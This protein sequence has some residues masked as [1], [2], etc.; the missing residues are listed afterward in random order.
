MIINIGIIGLGW[1]A[2]LIAESIKESNDNVCVTAVCDID[3]RKLEEFND[4][5]SIEKIYKNPEWLLADN[6]IDMVI[7]ATPPFLHSRFAKKALLS[8]KHIF[9]EKPG[10]L[11]SDSM[12]EL[13]L[14]SEKKGLKATIDYVMR[15]NPIYFILKEICDNNIFGSLE[16]ANLEN[17]AHDDH[18]PPEHWFW[19]CSKSGGIWVEHGVHF[20]D[21]V[22]WLIGSPKT[23]KAINLKRK[24]ENLI[25]KVFGI[26][27]HDKTIVSY[28]HGFTK[29]EPFEK[30]IFYFIFERAY[31]KIY[32]WIPIKMCIDA[33]ITP[34]EINFL[35]KTLTKASTSLS[36]IDI[37]LNKEKVE[38]YP[39][40]RYTRTC[41]QYTIK[42]N[43]W[44]VYK[45]CIM[46][47]IRDLVNAI[48]N[49][50]TPTV[51]LYDAK[52]SLDIACNME[53]NSTMY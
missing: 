18:M 52:R 20:F 36:K 10:A 1:F 21:V 8:G 24:G 44:D 30:T 2:N 47:G 43:R 53:R 4:K 28:Y 34:D 15:R 40:E 38:N 39:N 23:V 32:G 16:R 5:Y 22:N 3:V 45:K 14:I 49:K 27:L 46:A 50:D 33:L 12:E 13:I 35:E 48:I 9:L 19:D 31:V 26:A 17:F 42:E 29:P 6:D 7:I 25:D 41:L 51:T 11:T 37:N